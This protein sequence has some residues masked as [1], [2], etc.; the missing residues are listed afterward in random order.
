MCYA[1][2]IAGNLFNFRKMFITLSSPKRN[3]SLLNFMK[4][5]GHM[6][7]VHAPAA[8]QG[9]FKAVATAIKARFWMIERAMRE[10]GSV[11]FRNPFP[12]MELN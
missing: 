12:I 11:V 10:M 7:S 6:S 4:L 9:F 1:L 5:F 8:K 3:Y 2:W